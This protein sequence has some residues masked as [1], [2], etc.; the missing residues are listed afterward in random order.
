M[1]GDCTSTP[2]TP[3][4]KLNA[5]IAATRTVMPSGSARPCVTAIVCGKQLSA[6]RSTGGAPVA[7]PL[8]TRRSSA[9]ASAAPVASSRSEALA[10]SIAVSSDTMVWNVSNASSRPCAISDW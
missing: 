8:R 6:T 1:S 4:S 7:G 2:N 5:S 3:G 9:I 10:T